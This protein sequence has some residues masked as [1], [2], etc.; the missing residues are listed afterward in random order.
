MEIK[1]LSLK[2]LREELLECEN[3]TKRIL[4]KKLI[5]LK[6]DLINKEKRDLIERQIRE[7]LAHDEIE[8]C[9]DELIKTNSIN[10][11]ND[12]PIMA[13]RTI[14]RVIDRAIDS[15]IDNTNFI[16]NKIL[17]DELE[18][19]ITN[20]KLMDRLNCELD[21][22]KSGYDKNY[23]DKPYMDNTFMVNAGGNNTNL[24][25]SKNEYLQFS[26]FD[27]YVIPNTDFS[28]ERLLGKKRNL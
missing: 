1:D 13:S 12:A 27:K 25:N 26:E 16:D 20:N 17:K 21:F 14:D 7:K 15:P 10:I 4:I 9:V 28:S 6:K 18:H 5:K 19:D 8:T 11:K 2:K 3:S 22:R 24:F 23:I